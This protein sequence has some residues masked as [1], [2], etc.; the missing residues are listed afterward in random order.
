MGIILKTVQI[1]NAT[2]HLG[3]AQSKSASPKMPYAI[4]TDPVW[5]NVP[6]GMFPYV[7]NPEKLLNRV[8]KVN[9]RAKRVII[10]MRTDSDPRFL[11]AA[12][13][14]WKFF[15][16]CVLLYT[17]PN[18]LGR[19]LGG[20]EM[21]YCYGEPVKNV[22]GRRIIPGMSPK[23]QPVYDRADHPCPRHLDHFKWLIHW[24]S[25]IEEIVYDP[26]MGSGTTGV[27]AVQQGRRFVGCEINEDYFNIACQ[28]LTEAQ[29]QQLL[30][31]F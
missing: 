25:D 1:G 15:R 2:L 12:P 21:A 10:V 11:T 26:F 20:M 6:D 9:Q 31:V 4:I 23:V 5:P 19:K 14:K 3:D 17:L 30:A 8:L 28:R 24:H 13:P 7:D 16:T 27:A 29:K 18:Y 22:E